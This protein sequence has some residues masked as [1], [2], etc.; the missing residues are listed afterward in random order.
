MNDTR[1][2]NPRFDVLWDSDGTLDGIIGLMYFLQ[3]P[4]VTVHALTI[5]C[6]E[7]RPPIYA[8]LLPRILARV[9]RDAIPTAAGRSKP[10]SG[11]NAFPDDW[12]AWV[13]DFHGVDLPE[14]EGAI[15][16][17]QADE[18]IIEVINAVPR[19]VTLFVCGT[20][21]NL[22][23]ALRLDPG[24][25][26]KIASVHVMGGALYVPGNLV[27]G[28]PETDN[29]SAEWNIW[30]DPVA[31]SEVFGAG[32]PLNIVALD[33]T[34]QVLW[35][36]EDVEAWQASGTPEGC[37][38]AEL[39]RFALDNFPGVVPDGR[40]LWDL[41]A[42]VHLTNP[43]LF[44]NEPLH[45][46]IVTEPGPEEGRTEVVS[47]RAPNATA[48]LRPDA[49]GIRRVVAENLARPRHLSAGQG[50]MPGL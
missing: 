13:N 46:Q 21:T 22:A 26:E 14:V 30:V 35:T 18:L 25:K 28:V 15:D 45:I 44:Q 7:A 1:D 9:G 50:A 33:A 5:S 16:P 6:G 40:H 17:R 36:A 3:R 12:R 29:L 37:L 47:G 24:I 31:A 4:D 2:A 34:D 10:L 41:V 49:A 23:G 42:A 27:F 39:L 19:P 48:G 43:Q 20:H 8:P 32:L 38:A 11:E